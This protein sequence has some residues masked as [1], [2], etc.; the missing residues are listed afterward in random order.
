MSI[1]ALPYTS[2]LQV[3]AN[4][5]VGNNTGSEANAIGLTAE[6]ISSLIGSSITTIGTVT[7]GTIGTGAVIGGATITVGS[8][9]TGDV[10]YRNAGGVLTRLGVGST[11][12]VL[13]VAGGVPSWETP[14]G[15]GIG[16]ST[17]AVDNSVL[18][19][20]GTGGATLQNSNL[21]IADLLTASPNN[22]V[23]AVCIGP[24]GGTTNVD[25]VLKPKGSGAIQAH[26]ADSTA[27]GG[28]KR[29]VNSVDFQRSRSAATQVASGTESAVLGGINN[30]A[31]GNHCTVLGGRGNSVTNSLSAVGGD[32]SINSG[33][34][35]FVFGRG[36]S[37]NAPHSACFGYGT[38]VT[39]DGGIGAGRFC[40]VGGNQSAGFGY[41]NVTSADFCL[42]HG[43]WSLS[44]KYGQRSHASGR[45]AARGDAQGSE[46]VVR[47]STSNATQ[48]ELFLNGSSLRITIPTDTTWVFSAMVVARRTD[49]DNESAAYIIEGC[50]DNNAGTTA[51]VGTVTVT[52]LAEDNAAWDAVA[53]ADNTN[54]ALVFKVTAEA[55]KAVRW[56]GWVRLVEVTG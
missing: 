35:S 50:I 4:T 49:A 20:D 11:G 8:D 1:T 54:D 32:G 53:E 10:Y 48:T 25:L 12:Q 15:G 52:V 7:S 21:E 14:A 37:S 43:F 31:S 3:P 41:Y 42:T 23:N 27:T 28:N 44:N 29:G 22:T 16:G 19:A 34:W 30:T 26:V 36:A 17:G 18:R 46:L 47:N 55:A 2:V 6:Q 38:G 56:V 9:A 40:A 13:T 33:A 5:V 51:L 39:S 24:V 45:F